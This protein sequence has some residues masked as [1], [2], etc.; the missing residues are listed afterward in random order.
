MENLNLLDG[1]HLML[2]PVL[3]ENGLDKKS[4]SHKKAKLNEKTLHTKPVDGH[5]RLTLSSQQQRLRSTMDTPKTNKNS[6]IRVQRQKAL[7]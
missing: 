2:A 3:K 4:I 1:T 6:H 7:G 5:N